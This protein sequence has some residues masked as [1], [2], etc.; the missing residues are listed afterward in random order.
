MLIFLKMIIPLQPNIMKKFATVAKKDTKNAYSPY[1]VQASLQKNSHA[2]K[3]K[4]AG[5]L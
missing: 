3:Y 2:L 4:R 1:T 5:C